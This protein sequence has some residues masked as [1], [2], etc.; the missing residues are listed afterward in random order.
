MSSED[1]S[2][3]VSVA[4]RRNRKQTAKGK[5]FQTQLLEEQRSSAQ[6]SWRKQLNRI[7]N[8]LADLTEPDK[9][10]SERIFLESKMEILISAHER[11][12]EA[13][14][15]LETK[16]VAQK[17]FEKLEYE[18]SDALKR[19]NQKITELKE[20]GQSLVSSV[21]ASSRRSSKVS[22]GAK[23]RSSRSSRTSAIIDR[24][25][26][27]AV[28]VAKLKTELNFAEDEA[29]KIAELKK[30]RLTKELAI[31]EAEM[32]AID[33]V[34]ETQSEFSQRSEDMLPDNI[35]KDSC[36]DDLLRKYLASQASSVIEN[37][38]STMETNLSDKSK[39][40]PPK[41]ASKM[42][43]IVPLY[44][45]KQNESLEG[46]G[47]PAVQHPSSLNPF[48]PDYVAFSTPK[49]ARSTIYPSEGSPFPYLQQSKVNRTTFAKD[50]EEI[51]QKQTS[52][53][54][55]ERLADLMT[56]R[57]AHEQL[58]LPEPETFSGDL[59]HYPTWK[60]SFDTIVERRTDSPSQRLYYLGRYTTGEA[61][62]AIR[63]LLALD[64]EHAYREAR[65]ILSDR[66]GNPFLVANAYRKKINEWPKI[67]PNDGTSL[68][69][70][71]DFLLH[72]QSAMK[73]IKYLK[74][75]NDP[76]ENQ[77][78]LR[79]LPRHLAE[80]W[81]RE[82][83]RWLNK[84]EQVSSD[85]SA[86]TKRSAAY[87]PFS[88]FCEFLKKESRIACNPVTLLKTKEEGERK[89]E[90][91]RRG[92]FTG[93]SRNKSLSAGSFATEADEVKDSPRERKEDKR[94][95]ADHC[96]LCKK[97]HNLDECE[98]FAKMSQ[99]EKIEFIRS[100][101]ICLGCLKYGHMKKDCRGRKICKKCKG[102]HPTSLHIDT[103]ASQEQNSNEG[104]PEVISHH[105]E[106][107]DSEKHA[108]C[109]SHSLI[110]P[111]WLRHEQ[112]LQDKQL[113]YALLDDQ[114]DACFIKDTVLE[115]LQANGPEVQLKLSTVL[116]EEVITCKRIDGLIVQGVNEATSVRLPG[117]Y[118]REDIPAKRGQI[119]RPETA[120]NW[121]HLLR[122]ADQLMPYREDVEV[123]LL[124][125][126]N[127]ARAI[128]PT[129]V[130]PGR[131]DDPYA[132]KTSLGWG[133][134]G[135][136]NPNKSEEDNNHC[137]CHRIASLEVQPCNG[138][139][140]C[141]FALKTQAKEVF[142][143][144]QWAKMLELDFKETSR[145]EQPLS[146]LDRKFL[147]VLESNIRHRDDDHYEIPL[148]LKEEGLKL[149]NN[150]T[151]ALSRLE[152]LKQRLKRDRKYREHYET[153]MKDM[154]DKGQAERVPDEE[155]HLSNGRVW[156]IP[157]HGVYHP[158]KPD[159][160][161]VVFDTSAEFKGESLNR[162]LLQGPDLTNS[163]NG[164]LCRFRKEPIAFTCDVEGMFHQVYV[165]PD[166][167]NLLRFL[168]WSD[169]NIDSKPTEFR[170]TVHLFGA[171]SS[172]GCANFA[173]K[174]TA[175][176]FKELF[177]SEAAPFVKEDFYVDDGLK[178]VPSA[179]QA[180]ALIKSTKSLLA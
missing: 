83:D 162:H 135:V 4:S 65:K 34:E 129:E 145:E 37:S 131:E 99:T 167:R 30:F 157:Y 92:R 48:A 90:S 124:I 100:R 168:W 154:I 179:I 112:G 28:K 52:G 176:D 6:R 46:D 119:P 127:C 31:A 152:R 25:A 144:A 169:E 117:A 66:F 18:H 11:L 75:L 108:E 146:L 180:S 70:F 109:F 47:K 77:K 39:I 94:P 116:A 33:Q 111:V 126:A 57:H 71:S 163:L 148:P 115:K 104:I 40:V 12:V 160:I 15:D 143:P 73:E 32:K 55:L 62:E 24:R 89:E 67:Q 170:M 3:S 50:Q 72:C 88:A 7:E 29:A 139:R 41:P 105:V 156:Y 175:D 174:R 64:S 19:L 35:N 43:E 2:D 132:K 21:T 136:V 23:S 60:K 114:S 14:E 58:P 45:G 44:Q 103:P 5:Q 147:S 113:V 96:L 13:L 128:K 107:S 16:R 140:L 178:S 118:T 97:A 165:N 142:V 102:F 123:G 101:G 76:E 42:P 155:L 106:A 110:V 20:E 121:P 53:D 22:H 85:V 27:T 158:Q 177:G 86:R 91:Q 84:E 63:G 172:P 161:R 9:L 130:I 141:H 51:A 26:D 69:K 150:R 82:V 164:V 8:C 36:K 54:V 137:S 1:D 80:R 38:I 95:K 149:P 61:K 87:P 166:H 59:L 134:I 171:T 81:T 74:A 56:K 122:I 133:V 125:G 93:N 173:L 17:K 98:K 68:R 10:Q 159:K 138:K 79:K 151:L 78:M 153:F 49:N 120:R